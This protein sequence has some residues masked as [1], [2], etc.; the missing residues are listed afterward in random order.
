M[1]LTHE[2]MLHLAVQLGTV[3]LGKKPQTT[4]TVPVD[5][6][7]CRQPMAF[8][9]WARRQHHLLKIQ[10]RKAG[11]TEITLLFCIDDDHGPVS[12]DA[13]RFAAYHAGISPEQVAT[14]LRADGF[15]CEV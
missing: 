3:R 9:R 11:Y 7:M 13:C 10:L 2:Q 5:E 15:V 6:E 4:I 14:R 1:P 8:H 12:R